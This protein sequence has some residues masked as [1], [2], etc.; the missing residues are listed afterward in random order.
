MDP[1]PSSGLEAHLSGLVRTDLQ[2]R[3]VDSFPYP[4]VRQSHLD[5]PQELGQDQRSDQ[6]ACCESGVGVLQTEEKVAPV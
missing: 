5:L 2:R 6:R 3:D 4:N 1:R